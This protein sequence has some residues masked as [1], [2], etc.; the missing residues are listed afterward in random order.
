MS[1]AHVTASAAVNAASSAA[2][3]SSIFSA[4]YIDNF[5]FVIDETPLSSYLVL[6]IAP[7]YFAIL[8]ILKKWIEARAARGL[9]PFDLNAV[10]R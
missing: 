7:A 2:S 3:S 9:K 1:H 6:L 5:E 4:S 8:H 10:S